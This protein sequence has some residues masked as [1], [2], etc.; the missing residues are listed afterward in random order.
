[1][2]DL[3]DKRVDMLCDQTS[4]M[5]SLS[6]KRIKTYAVTSM[7]RAPTHPNL[8]TLHE[9]GYKSF[10]MGIWHGM[11]VPKGTPQPIKDKLSNSLQIGLR[12]AQFQ[13]R[14]QTLGATVLTEEA[15]PQ[16]LTKRVKQQVQQWQTLFQK[17][18]IEKQALKSLP[19]YTT[20]DSTNQRAM[21]HCNTCN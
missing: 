3:L 2:N 17:A 4:R 11:W 16:A 14:M 19:L 8:P 13:K 21:S 20:Q 5:T 9:S 7:T 15:T 1:M 12:D 6:A 18:G 10:N